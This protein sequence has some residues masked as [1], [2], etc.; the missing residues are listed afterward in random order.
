MSK[1][2]MKTHPEEHIID[3]LKHEL[4]HYALFELKKPHRDKDAYFKE[5]VDRLGVCRTRT[6]RTLGKFHIYECTNCHKTFR[7][8]RKLREGSRCSCSTGNN[9]KYNGIIEFTHE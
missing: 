1:E 9:L 3:V 6:Y 8:K 5:T 2:F 7:R 4:V